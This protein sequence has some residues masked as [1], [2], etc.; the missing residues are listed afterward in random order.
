MSI[1]NQVTIFCVVTMVLTCFQ[2]Y[3]NT[4]NNINLCF[5]FHFMN[6]EN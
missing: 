4:E 5:W 6:V 2:F 3:Q 1:T